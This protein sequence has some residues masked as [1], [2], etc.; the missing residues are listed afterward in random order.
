MT[1]ATVNV[2][3]KYTV[4]FLKIPLQFAVIYEARRIE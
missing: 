1:I 3:S 4:A 2:L